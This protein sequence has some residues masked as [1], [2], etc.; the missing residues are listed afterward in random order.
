MSLQS[1]GFI[2]SY[3]DYVMFYHTSPKNNILLLLCVDDVI[4][5][6]SDVVVVVFMKGYLSYVEMKDLDFTLFIEN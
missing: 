1:V 2:E 6:G 3:V 5:V 4:T